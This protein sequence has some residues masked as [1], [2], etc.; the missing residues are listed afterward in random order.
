MILKQMCIKLV[1]IQFYLLQGCIL[2]VISPES[3]IFLLITLR[4]CLS[5]SRVS[6]CLSLEED[7]AIGFRRVRSFISRPVGVIYP[8]LL[9]CVC[10]L[11]SQFG[12]NKL[13]GCG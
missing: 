11:N 1:F 8:H 2:L 9:H 7:E 4:V 10:P 6:V 12:C 13:C 5:V 3:C